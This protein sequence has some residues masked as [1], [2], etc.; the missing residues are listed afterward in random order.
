MGKKFKVKVNGEVFNVEVE[1][2]GIT[3][4]AVPSN[5]ATKSAPIEESVPVSAAPTVAVKKVATQ[6]VPKETKKQVE[7]TGKNVIVAPLPGKILSVKVKKGDAVKKGDL[8]LV[9]EAM[10]MENEIYASQ[11]GTV[12]DILIGAGDYVSTGDKLVVTE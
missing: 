7:T 6:S 5:I 10:K 11:T 2:V 12:T 8:V 1:E 9:I 3:N 4:E